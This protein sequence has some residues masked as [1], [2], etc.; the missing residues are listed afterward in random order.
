MDAILLSSSVKIPVSSIFTLPVCLD[1]ADATQN[2]VKIA[3]D[4][5]GLFWF[6]K[7]ED[8]LNFLNN[9]DQIRHQIS[10]RFWKDLW[11]S[12]KLGCGT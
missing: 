11:N 4:W 7:K 8:H 9:F 12:S 3:Y 10:V 2:I 5:I 6:G 1:L